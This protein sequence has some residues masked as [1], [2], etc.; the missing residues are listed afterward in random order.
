MTNTEEAIEL[1]NAAAR[2]LSANGGT[3]SNRASK[4]ADVLMMKAQ[5][6]LSGEAIAERQ[7]EFTVLQSVLKE[8]GMD[9][10]GV[11]PLRA[12]TITVNPLDH[13]DCNVEILAHC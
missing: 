2:L 3:H 5:N 9:I 12:L 11:A 10:S 7:M 1:S 6:L 8:L 4:L 13:V